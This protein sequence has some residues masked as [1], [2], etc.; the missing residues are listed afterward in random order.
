[1][2]AAIPTVAVTPA[3]DSSVEGQCDDAPV[4]LLT[5]ASDGVIIMW[6]ISVKR[7]LYSIAG[8]EGGMMA[9][10]VH[11]TGSLMTW[12]VM[13]YTLSPTPTHVPLVFQVP[14]SR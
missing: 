1:M 6:D 5:A 7:E 14:T 10:D 13:W 4:Y 9:Y 8:S 12:Y 11:V 2:F 3:R